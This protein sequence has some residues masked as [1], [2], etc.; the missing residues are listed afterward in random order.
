MYAAG[1]I[2]AMMMTANYDD[3]YSHYPHIA[4]HFMTGSSDTLMDMLDHN[5]ADVIFTLDQHIYRTDYR[6]I[7]EEPIK[8]NFVVGINSPLATKKK[9]TFEELVQYPFLLTE[10]NMSYRLILDQELAKRS[11]E[12]KPVLECE[13]T[14]IITDT[15][16][17]GKSVAFLPDFVTDDLHKKEELIYIEVEG[18]EAIIWKQLIIHKN[19]WLS[20][21]LRA[22]LEYVSS[23]EF[24][25]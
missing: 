24:Y 10:K 4:L 23:H 8:V 11:L 16:K 12:I 3:F 9:V 6:I 13:R 17:R 14:D 15:V 20:R 7:K 22:F 1:S 21:S 18:F 25:S 5:V 2:C 19:K